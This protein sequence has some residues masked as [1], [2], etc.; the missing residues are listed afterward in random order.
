M[1]STSRGTLAAVVAG[2]AAA[3]GVTATPATAA[4]P[5]PVPLGGAEQSLHME[6][7]EVTGELAVPRPGAPEGP[8]FS[9]SRLLPERALPQ[10]PVS[11]GLPGADA[12]APLPH[13][14]GDDFDHAAVDAPAS[15]LRALAPG[16]AL[17]P[18]LTSPDP[19]NYG[20]PR[21]R[22]PQAGVVTPAVQTVPT[23]DL[24]VGP[25]L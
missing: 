13:V 21:A 25:G 2:V 1:K 7:P 9:R 24:G 10:L 8:R 22:L 17:N 5:V 14:L 23:A 12:R 15:E 3:V 4:V 16:L 11:S 19:E 20:V 18:P 6:L